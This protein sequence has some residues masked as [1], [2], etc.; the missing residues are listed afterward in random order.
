M[1]HTISGNNFHGNYSITLRGPATGFILSKSQQRKYE[2]AL[3]GMSDCTC[4]GAY[5]G[6]YGAGTDIGSAGVEES[7]Y[8]ELR[9]IPAGFIDAPANAGAWE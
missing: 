2:T 8:D 9:L 4:G 7:N 3:C 6:G 1:N 5:G